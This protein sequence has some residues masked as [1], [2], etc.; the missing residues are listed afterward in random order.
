MPST[1]LDFAETRPKYL[2]SL[3]EEPED[4]ALLRLTTL[5]QHL[6]S[7]PVAYMGLI[8]AAGKMVTRIGAGCEYG[9]ILRKLPIT[10]ALSEPLI[11]S[12]TR[13]T[14]VPGVDWGDL[15]FAASAPLSATDGLTLGLLV[16]ADHRPRP[17]FSAREASILVELARVLAGKMELRRMA[18]LALESERTVR[19]IE[20]RFRAIANTAPILMACCGPDGGVTFVNRAWLEFTGRVQLDALG[21]GWVEAVHP[22]FR[23]EIAERVWQALTAREPIA[24]E[25]PLRRH[26]GAYRRMLLKGAPRF[27]ENGGFLGMVG[28][29]TDA[30]DFVPKQ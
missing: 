26:D 13:Q 1:S 8:D 19:E 28:C 12:D 16:I 6:F 25:V 30:G 9:A 3:L 22:E 17:E 14:L 5:V 2:H 4:E 18:A 29:M 15:R 20:G 11:F 23:E 10:Y 7:V 21:D 24:T 27:D